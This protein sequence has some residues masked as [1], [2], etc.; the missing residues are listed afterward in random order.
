MFIN[1]SRRSAIQIYRQLKNAWILHTSTFIG[2][3]VLALLATYFFSKLNYSP[4]VN[5]VFLLSFLSIG[6]WITEAIPP[7]AVGILIVCLLL[8]GFGTDYIFPQTK[9]VDKYIQTWT[10]HVIWLLMGGFFLAE[11]MK[12]V[13]LDRA[14]FQWT[15]KRFGKQANKL[16]LGL[17][18]VTAIASMVMS[19]TATTAMMLSSLM[20]LI[21]VLGKESK[22]SKAI[23]VGIPAAATVGGLGTIIGSTPNAIAVGALE[24]SGITIG[25]LEWMSFGVPLACLLVYAFYKILSKDLA[26]EEIKTESIPPGFD[27]PDPTKKRAVIVTL[28]ITIS[29]WMTEP[30]HGIPIA[31]TAGV[32]ILLLTLTQV[33]QAE[34]VRQL[35]WD[36]LMLVAGGLALGIALVDVGLAQ[37]LMNEIL[38]L[39]LNGLWLSLLFAFLAVGISN[40]MSNTAAA[41]ILM[42]LA[43]SLPAP[44]Q[45]TAPI[46]VA[47]SCSC[48][49]L[50]PVSTPANAVAYATGYLDQK[51]FR[52]GGLFFLAAGPLLGFIAMLLWVFLKGG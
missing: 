2:N 11:G 29:L 27:N 34:H 22:L 43:I 4:E 40:L 35:P 16:L 38:L 19:N 31:A 20:P 15:L 52:K 32:P 41:A 37:L 47:I 44:Y 7:F 17:M 13:G 24:S 50:L 1:D 3:S 14:L 8:A 42:P 18:L 49:L 6:L 21:H 25:F 33:I 48:A 5:Y 39:P 36:T 23:L 28:I 46:L 10:S 12:Q 45:I 51:D 26:K 30:L 9:P